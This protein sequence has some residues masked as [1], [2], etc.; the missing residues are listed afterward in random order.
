MATHFELNM[1][2]FTL[3]DDTKIEVTTSSQLPPG[4]IGGQHVSMNYTWFRVNGGEWF[5]TQWRTSHRLY[6]WISVCQ[7]AADFWLGEEQID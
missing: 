3:P 5:R 2:C 7:T 1:T 4:T 6:S